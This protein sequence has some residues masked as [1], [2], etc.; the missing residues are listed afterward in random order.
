MN[1]IGNKTAAVTAQQSRRT[2]GNRKS[3][4]DERLIGYS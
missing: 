2:P 3:I 1:A 4:G